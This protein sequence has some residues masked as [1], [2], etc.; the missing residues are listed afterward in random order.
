MSINVDQFF[1]MPFEPCWSALIFIEQ[2]FRSLYIRHLIAHWSALHT[3]IHH[4]L[5]YVSYWRDFAVVLAYFMFINKHCAIHSI[6]S[7]DNKGY[8]ENQLLS[9][10]LYISIFVHGV[11]FKER[12]E[13]AIYSIISTDNKGYVEN[14]LLSCE[15]YKHESIQQQ[16]LPNNIKFSIAYVTTMQFSGILKPFQLKI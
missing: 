5:I 2:H 1:S 8:V 12:G 13:C 16:N 4:V 15:L 3:L 7:T 10:E 14:Q 9:C 6:I 11:R